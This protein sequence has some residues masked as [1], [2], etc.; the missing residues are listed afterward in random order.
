MELVSLVRGHAFFLA[1]AQGS[2]VFDGDG[3]IIVEELE[4]NAAFLVDWVIFISKSNIKVSLGI[5]LC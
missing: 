1:R 3:H 5:G 2:E 4:D